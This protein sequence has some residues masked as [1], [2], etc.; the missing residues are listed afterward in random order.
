MGV[1]FIR[2]KLEIKFLILY[3]AARVSEPLPLEG[4]HELTMCDD[5]IDYFDFSECLNDLVQTEHLR[6][7]EE[8]RYAITPKGLKNSAICES[9]NS[10]VVYIT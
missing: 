4:M 7:T 10:A 1:G 9:S 3:I 8:G 5:G 2:D 6:L